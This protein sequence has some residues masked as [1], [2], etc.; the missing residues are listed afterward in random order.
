MKKFAFVL[1]ATVFFFG[2]QAQAQLRGGVR[3]GVNAATWGGDAVESFSEILETTGAM[4]IN[5][6]PGLHVGAYLQLPITSSFS[7]EPGIYYSSKGAEVTQTFFSN[8]FIKP[9][10]TITDHAHYVEVPVLLRAHLGPGFQLYAGPQLAYLIENSITAE[11][12]VLGA[13][14]EYNTKAEAGLRKFDFGVTGGLGYEFAGGINL[15]A[16]Y[17]WGLS[18]LDEGR[19]NVDAFNRVVKVSLGYTFK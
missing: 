4:E 5:M 18:T 13:S 3:I 19:S 2:V 11:A 7:L 1:L 8:S 10:A 15:Q 14:Y 12:G 6:K 16:G 9:K 17:E